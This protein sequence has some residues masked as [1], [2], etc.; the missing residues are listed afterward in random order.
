MFTQ[1]IA[2]VIH[3]LKAAGMPTTLADIFGVLGNC[4]AP[5][6]H[7]AP[8]RIEHS[9]E[10]APNVDITEIDSSN[11]DDHHATLIVAN[12]NSQ[13]NEAGTQVEGA[14]G[15]IVVGVTNI[16][17]LILNGKLVMGDTVVNP[18]VDTT[19]SNV[20]TGVTWDSSGRV[21]FTSAT[22]TVLKKVAGSDTT[23]DLCHECAEECG[24]CGDDA[25]TNEDTT[26]RSVTITLAGTIVDGANSTCDQA[27]CNAM[28]TSYVLTQDQTAP[29]LFEYD[30][31]V[32]G[33]DAFRM[34]YQMNATSVTCEIS[35]NS[36]PEVS[37]T[38]GLSANYDCRTA[39]NLGSASEGTVDACDWTNVTC[40]KAANPT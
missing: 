15:L 35:I 20:L 22:L 39:R 40:N 5:L 33:A 4:T 21:V 9:P 31:T 11:L 10:D 25:T 27:G 12:H 28:L 7:R 26:P 30:G 32:C 16:Q 6:E 37:W 18:P 8:I 17:D 36:V 19:T 1:Q 29:C 13:V 24:N 3:R 23:L 14:H 34:T 38:L 2:N